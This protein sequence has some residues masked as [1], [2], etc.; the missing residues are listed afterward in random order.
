MSR[1]ML[2][3]AG[4]SV[5]VAWLIW[6]AAFL[7]LYAI[8]L[9]ANVAPKSMFPGEVGWW[10]FPLTLLGAWLTLTFVATIG[11]TGRSIFFVILFIGVPAL[12]VAVTLFSHWG[13]TP[14]ARTTLDA[15]IATL[16]GVI[17]L[18]GTIWAF[19]AARRRSVISSATVWAATGAWV[20]LCVLLVLFWSQHRNEIPASLPFIVHVIGLLALV[21][22]PLA[23]APLALAWNRNR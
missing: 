8:L 19:A 20:A 9:L 22:F 11:Q 13:L 5:L 1:T 3:A 16:V 2:R 21:V 4:V 15:G 23:A 14:V 10:Y 12:T 17:Y 6:A 18:L 7:G